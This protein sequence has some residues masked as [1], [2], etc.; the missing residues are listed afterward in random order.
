M[1]G[2]F[3]IPLTESEQKAV[4]SAYSHGEKRALCRRAHAILLNNQGHTINQ[5]SHIRQARRDAVSRWET[6]SPAS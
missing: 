4:T 1:T 2:H 6:P 5:A 3:V